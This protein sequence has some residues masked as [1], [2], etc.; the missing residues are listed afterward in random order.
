MDA[1]SVYFLLHRGTCL[2][3]NGFIIISY[4]GSVVQ[5]ITDWVCAIMP[6]F[7]VKNLQMTRRRKVSLLAVLML[8]I[9]ASVI[10]LVRMP[11]YKYYDKA[12]YP[13]DYLCKSSNPR[14]LDV[15][16]T[17]INKI[18]GGGGLYWDDDTG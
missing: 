18:K 5:V 9:L 2:P 17:Y 6:F 8:G 11:F 10:S 15:H 16:Q 13:D 7:V 4:F 14:K 3:G 1:D 12:A